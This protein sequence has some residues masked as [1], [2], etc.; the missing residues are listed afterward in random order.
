[1]VVD[2]MQVEVG[3]VQFGQATLQFDPFAMV[4]F[5]LVGQRLRLF[6]NVLSVCFDV[7]V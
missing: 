7:F 1:M 5:G 2:F 3:N 4:F 6:Q